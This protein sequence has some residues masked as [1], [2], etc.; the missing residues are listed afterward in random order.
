MHLPPEN[1]G[2]YQ[3]SRDCKNVH[4][5]IEKSYLW[6]SFESEKKNER[7]I[8]FFVCEREREREAIVCCVRERGQG[9]KREL[10][11]QRM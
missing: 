11:R 5:V 9:G 6:P 7:E 8:A 1:C 3:R 10:K 4:S 2:A